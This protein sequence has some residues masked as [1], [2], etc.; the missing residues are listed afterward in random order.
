M[1]KCKR[2]V[3]TEGLFPEV[4]CLIPSNDEI[5]CV[6][7]LDGLEWKVISGKEIKESIQSVLGDIIIDGEI[8]YANIRNWHS[9]EKSDPDNPQWM[10]EVTCMSK[11]QSWGNSRLIL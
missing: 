5:Q 9:K 6:L 11:W 2:E 4:W 3:I 8:V 1:G 10:W 7:K